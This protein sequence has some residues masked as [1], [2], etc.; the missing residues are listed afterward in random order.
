MTATTCTKHKARVELPACPIRHAESPFKVEKA[1]HEGN[2]VVLGAREPSEGRYSTLSRQTYQRG[3]R[4]APGEEPIAP[5]Q[6]DDIHHEQKK[7]AEYMNRRQYY[8]PLDGQKDRLLLS[9]TRG[10]LAPPPKEAIHTNSQRN[11][12]NALYMNS[13]TVF[14][15]DHETDDWAKQ[16]NS[17]QRVSYRQP[18]SDVLNL[19]KEESRAFRSMQQKTH[20][21]FGHETSKAWNS[22]NRAM[23][24]GR[25]DPQG[26]AHLILTNVVTSV[27]IGSADTEEKETYRSLKQV[28]F[29]PHPVAP[30]CHHISTAL[31]QHNLVMGYHPKELQSTNRES[32]SPTDFLPSAVR[33]SPAAGAVAH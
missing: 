31:Q 2:S 23:Y 16:N 14:R 4:Q 1:V 11:R 26:R 15:S 32:Y 12:E 5:R 9:E 17:T 25:A 8:L 24:Q 7:R 21:A 13:S 28:D 19:V 20:F 6:H 33:H 3:A 22:E 10:Q 27:N 18:G 30:V 29:V